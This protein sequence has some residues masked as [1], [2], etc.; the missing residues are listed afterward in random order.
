MSAWPQSMS[1]RQVGYPMRS[2]RE[3]PGTAGGFENLAA[4]KHV[5]KGIP[6]ALDSPVLGNEA[7]PAHDLKGCRSDDGVRKS[8]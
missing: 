2:F 7:Q 3:E 4:H 5:K 1:H 8:L 6:P